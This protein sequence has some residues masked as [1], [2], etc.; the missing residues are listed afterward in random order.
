[1]KQQFIFEKLGVYQKAVEFA[2]KAFS[3]SNRFSQKVQFSL[4]DQ[5]RRASL[6][7]PNNIAEGS[8]RRHRA[9]KR[10]FFRT[11]LSSAFECIPIITIALKQNEIVQKEYDQIY[12]SCYEI[13]KM[14]SGLIKSV[15]KIQNAKN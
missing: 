8:G 9:E 6:S 3:I 5:L 1:M 7:I 12:G 11:A 4:G 13:S 14:I 10:Q 15:D 2:N